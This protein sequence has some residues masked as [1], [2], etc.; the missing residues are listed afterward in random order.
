MREAWQVEGGQ[1]TRVHSTVLVRM[2]TEAQR[3]RSRRSVDGV[4]CFV[5]RGTSAN[6][7]TARQGGERFNT[8]S[9]QTD[10]ANIR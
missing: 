3:G 8:V 4:K 10:A 9:Y 5:L 6:P 2:R 7:E 1:G